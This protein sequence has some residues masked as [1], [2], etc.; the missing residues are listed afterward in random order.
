[1]E[2]IEPIPDNHII[3]DN[4]SYKCLLHMIVRRYVENS[5][6]G[7]LYSGICAAL[8]T[9]SIILNYVILAFYYRQYNSS[10]RV[11][12]FM[13]RII[14]TFDLLSGFTGFLNAGYFAILVSDSLKGVI[15]E[16]EGYHFLRFIMVTSYLCTAFFSNT[17]VFLH[18]VL[19]VVRCINISA[20]FYQPWLGLIKAVLACYLGFMF[21]FLSIETVVF[22]VTGGFTEQYFY[23]ALFVRFT[24]F[25]KWLLI[26][27]Q[28]NL[29]FYLHII[30]D[31]VIP[32]VVP[33]V[34]CS[35]CLV[36]LVYTL[37]IRASHAPP[38][39]GQAHT[40]NHITRTVTLLTA[41]F[42]LCNSVHMT[43][44][45]L[46]RVMNITHSTDM[47]SGKAM[48]L[49][50]CMVPLFNSAVNAL[51]FILRSESLFAFLRTSFRT[52]NFHKDMIKSGGKRKSPVYSRREEELPRMKTATRTTSRTDVVVEIAISTIQRS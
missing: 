13:Y 47:H 37:T 15:C 24:M 9:Q 39:G 32:F 46:Q 27:S 5:W 35:V 52:F 22:L 34:I 45:C 3:H 23:Y 49:V 7:Y 26:H 8:G 25:T 29:V 14:S 11:I 31:L 4:S 2:I 50:S 12:P 30:L 43:L 10:N 20:P 42:V 21:A 18:T 41:L 48:F 36:I 19:T 51:I 28:G 6:E 1:M 16:K 38:A 44:I 33:C 17:T 40:Q